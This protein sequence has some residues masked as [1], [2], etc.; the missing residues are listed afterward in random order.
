MSM[1][2]RGRRGAGPSS[3]TTRSSLRASRPTE[4]GTGGRYRFIE[5][6]RVRQTAD[7]PAAAAGTDRFHL[8]GR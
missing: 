6:N 7:A 5:V 2:E 8:P 3:P 1:R 4:E